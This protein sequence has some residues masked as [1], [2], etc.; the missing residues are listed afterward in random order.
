MF[1][2]P[3][4]YVRLEGSERP[5]V[6]GATRLGP[7]PARA[8]I[9]VTVRVRRRPGA[10]PPPGAA[11]LA[12]MQ[13]GSRPYP[14][15]DEVDSQEGAAPGDLDAITRFAALAGLEV[16][17][18][19]APRRTIVLSGTVARMSAA[20]GVTLAEYREG[21]TTWR[22]REGFIHIPASLAPIVEGVFGLDNRPA[23]S[24]H[25]DGAAPTGT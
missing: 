5:A 1:A 22:G 3:H 23:A 17:A 11:A 24:S 25:A 9:S 16:T 10:P 13:S 7:A 2:N 19:S 18:R 6:A 4:G 21:Q 14:S 20:F 15:R 12:A 8:R